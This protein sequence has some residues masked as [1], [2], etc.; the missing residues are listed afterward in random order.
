[1]RQSEQARPLGTVFLYQRH[2][3]TPPTHPRTGRGQGTVL[4]VVEVSGS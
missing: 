4:S 2:L 3:P 1:M